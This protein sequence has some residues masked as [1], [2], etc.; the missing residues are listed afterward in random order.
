MYYWEEKK[1][2]VGLEHGSSDRMLVL[3]SIPI[4]QPP[5]TVK[6]QNIVQFHFYKMHILCVR[7]PFIRSPKTRKTI[8]WHMKSRWSLSCQK[9]WLLELIKRELGA[10]L[11][12]FYILTWV[13]L[14]SVVT[15]WNS[16][17]EYRRALTVELRW[18]CI[19]CVYISHPK[20][21]FL[22]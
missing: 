7:I 4:L 16:H 21:Y 13:L 15:V 5:P 20:P 8:L 14:F 1:L 12:A 3:C 22:Q 6:E 11:A 19:W 17:I 2:H 10:M 9:R 18:V